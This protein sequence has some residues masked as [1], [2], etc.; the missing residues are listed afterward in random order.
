MNPVAGLAIGIIGD[1]RRGSDAQDAIGPALDHAAGLLGISVSTDWVGTCDLRDGDP[2][3]LLAGYEGLWCAPGGR[4]VSM[5]GAL[6]GIEAARR[7]GRAFLGTCAGFQHGV[8]EFAR[9]VCGLEAAEH[10]EYGRPDGA[11]LVIDA[12]DCSLVGQALTVDVVDAETRR[13]YG[14]ASVTERYYCRFGLDETYLPSLEAGGLVVAGRDARDGTA[15][16]LRLASR[17]FYYLTLFV[18]QTSSMPDRPHPLVS[19]FVRAARSR[20]AVGPGL[21]TSPSRGRPRFRPGP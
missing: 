5:A 4:F 18:P 11:L 13:L 14:A 15:R 9:N 2:T 21:V 6:A 16:I 3:A 20:A 19:E 12:L 7:T 17:V 8:L 10:A 1:R